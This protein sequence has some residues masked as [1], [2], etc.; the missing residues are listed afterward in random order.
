MTKLPRELVAHIED[1]LVKSAR[2]EAF[3]VWGG[4]FRCFT[5][6]CKPEEHLT[7]EERNG[8]LQDLEGGAELKGNLNDILGKQEDKYGW[9]GEHEHR[10]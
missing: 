9:K 7:G 4:Q 2:Y 5:L 10:V 8:I 6:Q 1:L 3:R